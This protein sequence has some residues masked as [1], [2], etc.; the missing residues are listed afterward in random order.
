MENDN[1]CCICFMSYDRNNGLLQDGPSN[2]DIY[3]NC[4]CRHYFCINCLG[5]MYNNQIILCP[6][7]RFDFSDWI[8]TH[9]SDDSDCSDDSDE[10]S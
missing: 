2:S 8:N 7:C 4:S 1:Q 5:E 3:T 6:L 10:S 9:Y